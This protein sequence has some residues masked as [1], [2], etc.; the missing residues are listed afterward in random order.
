MPTPRRLPPVAAEPAEGAELGRACGSAA[1][2]STPAVE[3]E[4]TDRVL[5]VSVDN[6]NRL[7]GLAGESLV[8]SRWLKPFGESLLRAEAAAYQQAERSTICAMR[9]RSEAV[10]PTRPERVGRGAAGTVRVQQFLATGW[11]EV[12]QPIANRPASRTAST[13]R[14]SPAACGRSR[15]GTN[16]FRADGARR[17]RALGKQVRLEIVGQATPRSIA[18]SWSKLDAP[19]GH[20]L[21][22]AVDHGIEAPDE[23]VAAGKPP[24]GGVRLEAHHSAGALQIIV[25]DDGRG[26]DLERLRQTVVRARPRRQRDGR[27]LSE[28]ELLEFLFLPGFTM[29]DEVTE[30]SGRGVGLD[31]VQDMVKQVARHGARL[32]R[33]AASGTRFQLQLPITLSVVRTLLVEIAGE[34]YAFPLAHD[35]ARAEGA[36]GRRS[37]SS[38]AASISTSTAGGSAWSRRTRCW[39]SATVELGGD[40]LPVIVVG[41]PITPVRPG[42]RPLPRRARA[43]RAAARPAARQDQGHQR[44]RAD[45]GRLAGADRRRRGPDPL[46]GQAGRRPVGST[47]VQ[48]RR[49]RAGGDR[50]A[51]ACSSSTT[52]SPC[53]SWSASSST[54]TATRSRSRSTAWTAG[55]PCAAGHFDLVVTDIDMPRMDGIEL[56]DADQARTPSLK[57]LPVMI[58]SYKDREEDRRRGLEAGADYYLTKG[59]FHDETLLQAVV[60]LI[61]EA[62]A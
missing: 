21:R 36:E 16:G 8:E 11:R 6:L 30:I 62:G 35:R 28:A 59:S 48:R 53:A 13:T 18:T 57:S 54:A 14:R 9:F 2:K 20:L 27:A 38:R 26:V 25:S 1:A 17:R 31:V 23:R 42:R 47:R 3:P 4:A 10:P 58:V 32:V 40:E 51:S 46:D 19:L 61:G 39:T 49:R 56:V 52:R 22:N 7:L 33:S 24:E 45:G 37:R 12:D 15:D 34:P 55:T 43:G 41:E 5:R 44:R 60:D 29:K 50:S